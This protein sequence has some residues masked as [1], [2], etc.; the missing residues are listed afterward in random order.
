MKKIIGCIC[1]LVAVLLLPSIGWR[2]TLQAS[3]SSKTGKSP[4]QQHQIG[5]VP[6][7]VQSP[8][9]ASDQEFTITIPAGQPGAGNIQVLIELNEPPA[10]RVFASVMA[11]S[12]LPPA[13][14]RRAASAAAKTQIATNQQRQQVLAATLRGPRFRAREVYRVQKAFNGISVFLNPAQIPEVRSLPGVKAVHIVVPEYPSTST[15]I[16]FVGAPQLWGNTLGLPAG[17]DGTGIRIGIIDSGIDY[18]HPDFGGTGA[19]A[20]YQANNRTVAPDAFFPTAKVVGGKDFCGDAYTGSNAPVPDNDPMDCLGHGTHVA[21][22]AAGVGVNSDGTPYTGPYGPGTPFGSMRIGPG[23]APKA[24]LYAL[25]VFGCGGSTGLTVAAIDWSMDPNGDADMS[26]HLDVI[27]MSLGS[28]FGSPTNTSAVASDNAALIGVLV[29]ASAGNAGDTYFVH[30]AP[31]SSARTLS[32]AASVDSGINISFLQ[33]NSPVAIAGGY[34]AQPAAFTPA[35]PAPANQTADVVVALDPAD[36]AGPTTTDGC[37]AFTNAAAIAGK[38]ALI[39]RGTCGFQV[40]VANAQAAGAIGV[41]VANN[42]ANDPTLINMGNT[43]GQPNITIPSVFVTKATGDAIKAQ[44]ALGTVNATLASSP[45]GDTLASFSSRG[46]RI[47]SPFALKPDI[48]APGL[49]ITSAQTGVTCTGSGAGNTGCIVANGSGFISGGQTLTISGT[50]MAAPHMAGVMALLRQLHPTW[51]VEELKALAMNGATHDL[52]TFPSGIGLRF[53]PSRIGAGRVDVP[54]SATLQV[55][56]FNAEDEGLVSL[57][58]DTE[59]V[60]SASVTK[61]LKLI[62]QGGTTATYDLAIDTVVDAPGVAFSLPGGSS[63]TL[64]PG[65]ATEIAVQLDAT[66]SLMDHTRD[67][68]VNAFQT[69]TGTLAALGALNRQWLTE[70]GAYV[71]FKV[72]GQTKLRV[73]IYTALRPTSNMSAPATIVTG[74]AGSGSTT[75]ALSGTDVCTGT[76]GAGP[77]CTGTFPTNDQSVVSPFEL[78][79]VS[80]RNTSIPDFADIQYAGVAYDTTNNLLLFG[81]STWGDWAT[82]TDMAVNVYVDIDNNGTFDRILFNSNV[83]SMNSG[84][85]G[86]AADPQDTFITAVFNIGTNGV[87]VPS[88]ASTRYVN[89]NPGLIDSALFRN[90]VMVLSISPTTL[91]LP[92]ATSPFKYKVLTTVGFSP[93]SN[94]SGFFD[95]ANGPFTWSGAAQGLNFGGSILLPDLNGATIPVTWNTANMTANGSLGALLLHHFNGRGN[96]AEVVVLDTATSADLGITKTS[97]PPN[98][99]LGQNVT[100]TITVTNPSMTAVTGVVVTDKLPAGLTY[101][102]DDG[103]GA[104]VPATGL[105]TVGSLAASASATLNVVATLTTTDPVANTAQIT[106]ASPLDTNPANN[107][108][109]VTLNAAQSADLSIDVTGPAGPVLPGAS[110]TYTLKVTNLGDDPAYNVVVTESFPAFP[111]LHASSSMTSQGVFNSATGVWSIASLG[112]GV[113]DTL[114]ITVTAPA[115]CNGLTCQGAVTSD[116][117]DPVSGNNIDTAT[118]TVSDVT[119]PTITCPANITQATAPTCPFASGTVVNYAAPTV[120]DNCG[121]SSTVCSPPTGSTF[122]VGTTTVTCTVTDTSGNTASCSF[123]VSIFNICLQDDT[124]PGTVLLINSVTGAYRFC[125]GGTVFTGTG[126]VTIRGCVLTLQHNPPD[127]RVSASVDQTQFK[128]NAVIQFPV[129]TIKCTITDRDTRN[130]TCTCQ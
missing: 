42:V 29:V 73:P 76:L 88:G 95:A 120:S 67:A 18:Q 35:P 129:G 113:T 36:G 37:S 75:I 89:R 45:G 80:P 109:K 27:N 30:G 7:E 8:T 84:V 60:G 105:W 104:Y 86:S 66:A 12:K 79:V 10:T 38:I 106:A 47:G 46:P 81:V 125:C 119:P 72:S 49:S 91:G 53:G 16:P 54:N 11:A 24:T 83:G 63:V 55:V 130:N 9:P 97:S 14:A 68:T 118:T 93:L 19:L 56:A 59:V 77:T 23:A 71:T 34:A 3:N 101:V 51:T 117:S 85:F 100:F 17:A 62:N 33:V 90:N 110:V 82:P 122:P 61:K 1:I 126:T 28:S 20:D 78:Q 6:E 94:F 111:A 26:D 114:T 121:V 128:G 32:V 96:R 124:N 92:T 116:V 2:F 21:G 22:I 25:R 52:T 57:T 69:A 65:Q 87:S 102:S 112:K 107:Q 43:A 58:F 31:A 98:P 108:A 44:L 5:G 115:A 4:Q 74:G 13:E 50:S 103:G 40:K 39:D 99:T 70:E 123:T 41:I 48:A 127:R 15:S 64:G